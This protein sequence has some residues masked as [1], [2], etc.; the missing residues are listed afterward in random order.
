MQRG[1]VGA[2]GAQERARSGRRVS[3][4]VVEALEEGPGRAVGV[5]G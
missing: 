4:H 1:V 2:A 5:D 3:G